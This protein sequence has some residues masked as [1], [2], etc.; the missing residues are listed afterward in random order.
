V[1]IL[2]DALGPLRAAAATLLEL[3]GSAAKSADEALATVAAS[4]GSSARDAV[5]QLAAAHH[6][7]RVGTNPDALLHVIDLAMRLSE[8]A[9]RVP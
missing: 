3:E 4:L 6:G 8:R 5:A 7:D 2:A 1:R 9:A